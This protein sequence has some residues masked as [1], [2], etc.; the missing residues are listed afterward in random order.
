[1]SERG[2]DGAVTAR[3]HGP[4]IALVGGVVHPQLP[5]ASASA[6]IGRRDLAEKDSLPDSDKFVILALDDCHVSTVD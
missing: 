4:G 6:G 1:M 3:N 5:T 2:L